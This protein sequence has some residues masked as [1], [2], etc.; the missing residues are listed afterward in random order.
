MLGLRLGE[1]PHPRHRRG[2]LFRLF[3]MPAHGGGDLR[4]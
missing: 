1:P 2:L 4:A 3:V